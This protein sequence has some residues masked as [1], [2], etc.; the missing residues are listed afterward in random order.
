[1]DIC[2]ML[3]FTAFVFISTTSLLPWNLFMNAHEYYHYKLRNVTN[4]RNVTNNIILID[5]KDYGTELQRSYEG[6]L[7][8]T[9]GI[10]CAFGSGINFL[11]TQRRNLFDAN[12]CLKKSRNVNVK[13]GALEDSISASFII[14]SWTVFPHDS[15]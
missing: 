4:I 9:G 2:R 10:S 15:A 5:E 7:T 12:N 11:A 13:L 14:P 6:Y 8:L 1:M 3:V